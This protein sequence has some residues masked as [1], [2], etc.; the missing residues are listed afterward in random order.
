V[1]KLSSEFRGYLP[2]IAAL[3]TA[4]ALHMALRATIGISSA[5]MTFLYVV[6]LLISAW[7]GFGPGYLTLFLGIAVVP[8]L[9]RSNFALDKIDPYVVVILVVLS[10]A[11][12]WISRVRHRMEYA[13]HSA[14]RDAH[15][16]LRRQFAE[17]ENLYAKLPIGLCFLDTELRYVR[18]NEEFAAIHGH[19]VQAHIGRPHRE[20]A[21]QH[22]GE[23]LDS[24]YRS[25][26]DTGTPVVGREIRGRMSPLD[27]EERDWII[28]CS[29]V[30]TD[31]AAV[32][33]LQAVIQEISPLKRAE[34]ALSRA[35]D[36]LTQFTYLAAHDLQEPLRI[37]V[38]FS[39]LARRKAQGALPNDADAHLRVVVEAA[40]R[41]SQL[42]SDVLAYTQASAEPEQT[43]R[44][45][46]L[47]AVLTS[48]V[49]SLAHVVEESRATILRQPLPSVAGDS[50]RLSQVFQNLISNAIK[51]RKPEIPPTISITA[52]QREDMWLIAVQD[53]GEGFLEEY[54]ERIFGIFKRLHGPGVPGSGIGLAICKAVVERH[55]GRIWARSQLGHGAT[56][57]FTLPD[58]SQ[59]IASYRTSTSSGGG[60]LPVRDGEGSTGT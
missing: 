14:N 25:V 3:A 50:A 41:M 54:A 16:A 40:K 34:R 11:T 23:T 10:S 32:L 12:S 24:I 48:V 47:D 33:G 44:P 4:T 20:M 60:G 28:S 22:A 21:D 46:D 19:A 8:Y 6:A 36:E 42:I 39:E 30:E 49:E 58:S 43:I 38:T 2:A 45:V 1:R 51:Y 5:G 31:E 37:I 55:G 9:Y 59:A 17:L 52:E 53:N 15:T 29:R 27:R 26:L 35:N 7:C 18:L 57:F 56:F 13:L